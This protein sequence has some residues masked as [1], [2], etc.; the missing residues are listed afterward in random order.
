MSFFAGQAEVSIM[1]FAVC[2]P[3]KVVRNDDFVFF[4]VKW[5]AAPI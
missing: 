3:G 5:G 4:K 1:L 2:P